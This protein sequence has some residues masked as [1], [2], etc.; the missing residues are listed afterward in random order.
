MTSSESRPPMTE[1]PIFQLLP[2]E[3]KRSRRAVP[4][5]RDLLRRLYYACAALAIDPRRLAYSWRALPHYVGNAVSYWRRNRQRSFRIRGRDLQFA[6]SDR[7]LGAASLRGHYFLQDLWAARHLYQRGVQHH[8]DIGS[9]V[10][11]FIAHL[12]TFC[13]VTHV[14]IR[15]LEAQVDGLTFRQGSITA[16]PFPDNSV[17]SLSCLHVIEHVGLGRYGDS[18]DPDGHLKAAAELSRVLK[19]GRE[20]LLGTPVGRERLCFDAHRVFDP[21]TIPAMLEPLALQRFALI[22]DRGM[23]INADATF[24]EA[25]RCTYGCGLFVFEKAR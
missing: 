4:F 24:E 22:D 25:R 20:L 21:A 19:P 10:D 15:P 18:I 11:G 6:T 1:P 12:L 3:D 17:E 2:L 9:R 8:T 7:F 13:G 16:L 23:D 14:D 5:H